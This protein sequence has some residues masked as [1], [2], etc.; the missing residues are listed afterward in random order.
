MAAIYIQF[1]A[2][3][4][5]DAQKLGDTLRGEGDAAALAVGL[6]PMEAQILVPA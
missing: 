2:R 3:I 5:A 6:A 4:R 1:P